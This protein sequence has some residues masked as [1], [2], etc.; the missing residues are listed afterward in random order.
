MANQ[1]L[2]PNVRFFT[3]VEQNPTKSREKGRPIYDEIEAVEISF[4]G[5]RLMKRVF[6]A[7]AFARHHTK[8]DG[9][10]EEQTY[11]MRFSE[12]YKRFKAGKE[13]AQDGTP[14]EQLPFLTKGKVLE[15]KALGI[16][17]AENLAA[18]DGQNLKNLGM[19]GREL[20]SQAQAYLDRSTDSAAVTK[21]AADNEDL[22][23]QLKALQEQMTQAS[24][25]DAKK[26]PGAAPK[27]QFDGME[28]PDI[29]AW[30]KER[31]GEAPRGNPSHETLVGMAREVAKGAK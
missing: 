31:T 27:D 26:T 22:R 7:Q 8:E 29:K 17:T 5:D 10:T 15:L 24:E 12:H 6:P 1:E 2:A 25:P 20:K 30:I 28:D 14:I 23:A 11:A 9:T 3:H 16:Y 21:L 13:Q 19:N 18:L 4:G